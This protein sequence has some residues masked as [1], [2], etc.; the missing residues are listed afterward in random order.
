MKCI[1]NIK[2]VNSIVF[3]FLV[4]IIFGILPTQAGSETIDFIKAQN[5]LLVH[6]MKLK[7]MQLQVEQSKKKISIESSLPDPAIKL[8]I[9]NVPV[10][11]P[12]FNESDMTSKEIGVYQMIPLF[13][14]LSTKE[15]I[16]YL[17]YKKALE[18]YR[19][20]QAYY[21]HLMRSYFFEIVYFKEYLK[22]IEETK[23]YLALLIDIQKSRS[24]TGISSLSDIL[25]ISVE[26]SKLDEEIITV[27]ASIAEMQNNIAYLLGTDSNR[28][29][30]YNI[31]NINFYLVKIQN[32][33]E[34]DQVLANNPELQL[35]SLQILIDEEGVKL[36]QKDLYPDVEVGIAYMQ[37]DKTPQGTSR[38]D[39]FTVMATFNIPAWFTSKNIPS[40][41]EMKIKKGESEALHK[42]KQNELTFALNTLSQNIKKWG[43]LHQ[44][45]S[46]QIIP[47][48]NAML[49]ADIAYYR[50]G[51]I[52]FM[53]LVDTIRM[54][55][56]YKL[57]LLNTIKEYCK[58][59][60]FLHFMQGDIS[61]M[62]WEGMQ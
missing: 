43:Q 13:G 25:K 10:D 46:N 55:L 38:D 39:M 15:R 35:L 29:I 16:A 19:L 21:L 41:Q 11:T 12:S 34:S 17:E 56:N 52:E 58:A 24:T 36:K 18:T 57:Q 22:I 42:D 30:E 47:Q 32:Q 6:N 59:I 45:Y 9:N 40:I 20:Y 49:Q 54:R 48:L 53:K 61:V 62:D 14:K 33:I 2:T 1:Y 44:L 7:A 60:S 37:R 51:N 28:N 31:K 26:S 8:G 27:N 5:I 23:Q 4:L 50:A 3:N